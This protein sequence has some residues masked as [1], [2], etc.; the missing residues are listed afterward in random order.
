MRTRSSPRPAG[1]A[2]GPGGSARRRGRALSRKDRR[3]ATGAVRAPRH[4]RLGLRNRVTLSFALGAFA[5]SSALGAITYFAARSSILHD[6]QSA[7]ESAA[8]ANA[9][10]LRTSISQ[11][12]GTE[13]ST[14]ASIDQGSQSQ[15]ALYVSGQGWIFV[16]PTLHS[17][18]ALP[19]SLRTM[20]IDG[21]A[22][23]QIIRFD[24]STRIAVGV[25][26]RAAGATYFE[27]FPLRPTARTLQIILA[28]L[29]AAGI[30]TTVAG[31]ILGRWAAGRALRPLR[32]VSQAALSIASGRLDTRL[33]TADVRDLALL[34]S[35]FNRMVDRL[36]QRIE[37]DARFTSDV[38][39]ELRSPLTTL[40]ASLSVLEARR[41]DLPERSQKALGLLAAEIR[42]FQR[43]VGDLLEI[44]RLDAGSADF[45]TSVVEVGELV[46]NAVATTGGDVAVDVPP[47]TAGR[48]LAV[49]KRRFERI[50]ANLLDNARRYAGGATRV[51]VVEHEGSVR[52]LVDDEG[53][54]IPASERARV[55]ERFAR[56]SAAAGSRGAG[57]GTGLGLAL[58]AEH[59]KLHRGRVWV[60]GRHEGGARFVVELPLLDEGGDD[61][62]ATGLESNPRAG[63]A[64][65]TRPRTTGAG[66]L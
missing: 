20:A 52:V 31:T 17:P 14:I 27:V 49:D 38:S 44:S 33:E 24:R 11:G 63:R 19:R 56:G 23:V 21:T 5:L 1:L 40:A 54:G 45:E 22:A 55:F 9:A 3:D 29:V 15:S 10:S 13:I 58:V 36:Q 46:R 6:E 2:P 61:A 51:T 16:H 42:R 43:M 53:P 30:V 4:P 57:D 48:F 47:A 35:S 28:A 32:D 60:E 62:D 7:I 59:V 64:R 37:R 41:E 25:P 39:H 50:M 34:A 66:R 18:S 26:I 12:Y 8:F 65:T